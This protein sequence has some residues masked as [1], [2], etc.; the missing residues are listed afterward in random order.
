MTIHNFY[1]LPNITWVIKPRTNCVRHAVY[2]QES[3]NAYKILVQK[4]H[5]KRSPGR[6]RQR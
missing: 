1:S 4:P 2:M 6:L 3:K 5:G